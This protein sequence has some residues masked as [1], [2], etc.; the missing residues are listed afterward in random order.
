MKLST[1]P[2]IAVR[3]GKDFSLNDLD[4]NH[5]IGIDSKKEG[6]KLLEQNQEKLHDLLRKLYAQDDHAI[7]AVFQARDAAGKDSTIRRVFGN[8]FP[9]ATAVH[10]FKAPSHLE[11]EHDYLWRSTL[12]LPRRGHISI[13][14]RSY[15]EEVL[16]TKVHP[17][18][19]LGQ[20][21]PGIKSLEQVNETFWAKRYQAIRDH[22]RHLADNGTV[23]LKFFLNVGRD[24]QKRRFLDRIKIQEKNWKFSLG[25]LRERARWDDYQEAYQ[26]AI[27]ETAEPHAPWYVIP[28][29][30]KWYMRALVSQIMVEKLEELNLRYPEVG[31]KEKA[32]LTEGKRI[33]ETES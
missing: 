7:L 4:T 27:E 13:F 25:D 12:K 33:L 2:D 30:D 15:Y 24:E 29:D 18:Y 17:Q 9:Q 10:S 14:N 16:V 6:K 31:E 21:I 23:I 28:A 20:R 1:H 3:S 32:E 22:E 19:I 8:A 11:L 26:K 5:H